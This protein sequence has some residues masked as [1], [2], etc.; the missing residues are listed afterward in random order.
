MLKHT[1][2]RVRESEM[3]TEETIVVRKA[4]WI[5]EVRVTGLIWL[6]IV[7]CTVIGRRLIVL[8]C[9]HNNRQRMYVR[10]CVV[11]NWINMHTNCMMIILV[12]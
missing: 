10:A 4:A 7:Q 3:E 12:T 5:G 11:P 8:G 6:Q 9:P 2:D 1:D